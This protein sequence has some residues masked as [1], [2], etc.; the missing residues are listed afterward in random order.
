MH[1]ASIDAYCS[2]D[3]CCQHWCMLPV[4]MEMEAALSYLIDCLRVRVTALSEWLTSFARVALPPPFAMFTQYANRF[5]KVCM[6]NKLDVLYKWI[7]CFVVMSNET[8]MDEY[9]GLNDVQRGVSGF[10]WKP[11]SGFVIV[12]IIIIVVVV[13]WFSWRFINLSKLCRYWK[14]LLKTFDQASMSV[15]WLMEV[16]RQ[17]ALSDVT[18]IETKL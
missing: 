10:K 6:W 12:V 15:T 3:A 16:N 4:L 13:V 5:F 7:P 14:K 17:H 1:I 2:I 18:R 11:D 8:W 9:Q